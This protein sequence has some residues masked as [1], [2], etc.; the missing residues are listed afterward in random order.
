MPVPTSLATPPHND[1]RKPTTVTPVA[2]ASLDALNGVLDRLQRLAVAIRRASANDIT[3]RVDRYARK[4]DDDDRFFERLSLLIIHG[5]FPDINEPLAKQ[6]VYTICFRRLRLLYQRRHQQKLETR[7]RTHDK[8]EQVTGVS[9]QNDLVYRI[10]SERLQSLPQVHPGVSPA[11]W[12]GLS[13]TDHST[14]DPT[15]FQGDIPETRSVASGTTFISS[16][17]QDHNYPPPPKPK[18]LADSCSCPWCFEELK[19]SKLA[20]PGWWRYV[21]S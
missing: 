8:P 19:V 4:S 6:L 16:I 5:L 9:R 20:S 7:R 14:L 17:A 10:Q 21:H 18:E 3:S 15:K 12:D 1:D 2:K 13:R 11:S